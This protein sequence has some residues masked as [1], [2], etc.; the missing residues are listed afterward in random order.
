MLHFWSS[1]VRLRS[2]PTAI[3]A[4]LSNVQGK[5]TSLG[6]A[7]HDDS[8][9]RDGWVA[10]AARARSAGLVV[11][12]IAVGIAVAAGASA[13]A[14]REDGPTDL[15]RTASS[16]G[17]PSLLDRDRALQAD[18]PRN[19][20]TTPQEA[21]EQFLTAERDGDYATSF[22]YLADPVRAE[23]GSAAVWAADH[24]EALAPVLGFDL[25]GE[26]T[27]GD[28]RAEV[29]TL[30]RYRSS[31]DAVAG[32]VPA[33]ARTSWVVVEEEGGWAVDASATT[34]SVLFPPPEAAVQA[35]QTWADEA[36]RCSPDATIGL[37]GRSELA[38]RLCGAP[39][40]PEAGDVMPLAQIDAPPLQTSYGA[41]V[42]SWAR[43]IQVDGPVPLRAVVAPLDDAWSVI[44]VL[45]PGA[46]R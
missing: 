5:R 1:R 4:S 2:R 17:D 21:V 6:T 44:G 11:G 25:D 15:G 23:Y 43:T 33:R 27:G 26:P 16:P 29:A 37:R 13:L 7:K 42:V 39:G 3:R 38:Q 12:G 10:L 20:A 24:P 22:G 28:G 8:D 19:R 40:T 31:L 46:G 14:S 41:D 30:T 9:G 32:L 35:V 18:G 45:S 36:Q 34:Q